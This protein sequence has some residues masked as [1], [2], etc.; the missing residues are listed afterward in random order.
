[1]NYFSPHPL[2]FCSLIVADSLSNE[3]ILNFVKCIDVKV[4]FS[5]SVDIYGD[6]IQSR[7]SSVIIPNDPRLGVLY[8][9][10]CGQ[11]FCMD[12]GEAM[13]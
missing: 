4:I 1:M 8:F 10:T 7:V 11:I 9:V 2:H 5:E 6:E 12:M 3:K 13:V